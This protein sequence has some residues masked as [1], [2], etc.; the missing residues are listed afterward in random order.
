[1]HTRRHVSHFFHGHGHR[2]IIHVFGGSEYDA[3]LPLIRQTFVCFVDCV[4][5]IGDGINKLPDRQLA[6]IILTTSLFFN[7]SMLIVAKIR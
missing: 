3:K 4:V 5:N 6:Y 2:K 1:M 7:V